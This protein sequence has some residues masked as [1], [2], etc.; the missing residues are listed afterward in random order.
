VIRHVCSRAVMHYMR[1]SVRELKDRI[2]DAAQIPHDWQIIIYAG[3]LFDDDGF[4]SDYN[5]QPNSVLHLGSAL[6]GC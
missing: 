1:S 6:R 5:V 2:F 4:I 3:E